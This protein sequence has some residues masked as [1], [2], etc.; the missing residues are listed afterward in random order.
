MA[1]FRNAYVCPR[2]GSGW[3]DHW[4][5]MCDDD[6]RHCGKRHVSPDASEDLTECVVADGAE[7]VVLRSPATAERSPRYVEV[8]RFVDAAAARRHV[9]RQ[10]VC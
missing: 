5:A 1:W 4:S 3:T 9:T 10:R 7:F 8:A 6:C 2:C